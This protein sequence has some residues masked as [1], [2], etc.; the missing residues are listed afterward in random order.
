MPGPAS[1]TYDSLTSDVISYNERADEATLA[2]QLP[3][4]IMLAE[5]RIATELR[6]LGTQEVVSGTLS[7]GDPVLPKPAYWRRTNSVNF[8]TALGRRAQLKLRTYE[9]CRVFWPDPSQQ[10]VPRYYAD[11]DFDNLFIAPTPNAALAFELLYVARLEPLSTAAQ[12]NWLTSNAPQ[13]LL[14][15][16]LLETEL[17]LKNFRNV[18]ARKAEYGSAI[19]G[20]KSEDGARAFDRN[21]VVA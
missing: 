17:W 9:F 11:Y 16:T 5:N 10:D 14:A 2:A 4:L 21:I 3:R 18:D 13:L 8:T 19:A 6:I 15:A 7:A 20:F 12:T 1:L